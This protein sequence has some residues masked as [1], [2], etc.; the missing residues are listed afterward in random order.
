MGVTGKKNR[1]TKW[2]KGLTNSISNKNNKT[3][4]LNKGL[5]WGKE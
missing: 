5:D 1:T 2:N 3:T 4:E